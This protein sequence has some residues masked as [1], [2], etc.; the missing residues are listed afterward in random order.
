M[1]SWYAKAM[2]FIKEQKLKHPEMNRTQLRRHCSKNYPLEERAGYA[3]KAFLEAMRD[4][5]GRARRDPE[6]ERAGQTD[7]IGH[8]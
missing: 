7:F 8:G 5:F 4:E 1:R 3:Y 6:P 2:G